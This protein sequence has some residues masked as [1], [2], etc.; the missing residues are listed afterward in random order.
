MRAARIVSP[1]EVIIENRERPALLAG[2]VLVEVVRCGVGGSDLAAYRTASL[3]SP[4]WFGHEWV[5]RVVA[6]GDEVE[7]RFEGE[8]VIGAVPPNCGNCRSC[9]AGIPSVCD[10]SLSLILGTDALASD[11]GA[12][13]EVIRVDASR[14]YRVH[15]GVD[16]ADAALAEPASVAAHA[17]RRADQSLGDVVAVVGVGTIGIL[18]AELARLAGASRVVA[19]DVEAGRRELACSLGADAAFMPGRQLLGWLEEQGHGLGA[20]VVFD[21]AG[22]SASLATAVDLVR[23]GGTIV[24]VGRAGEPAV[25]DV[26][27]LM[28]KEATV[29]ASL[30][31]GIADV[32]RAMEL[33]AYDRFRV[34]ALHDTV[35]G[36]GELAEMMRRLAADRPAGA[37]E[38][39]TKVLVDP[40]R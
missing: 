13:A 39:L 10:R 24:I 27:P 18:T 4:A 33:M 11:H 5:G 20:D 12:F 14:L 31:Y 22:T 37:A 28:A 38:I 30:G 35:I 21:C 9:H 7:G 3:P 15:E 25:F 23:R 40:S 17:V 6:I 34:E 2:S 26:Q 36:L 19:V 8:R 16:D 32:H 29:T 1:G